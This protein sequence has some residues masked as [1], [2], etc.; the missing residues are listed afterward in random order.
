MRG[1]AVAFASELFIDSSFDDGQLD[2]LNSASM[3]GSTG[4]AAGAMV[5]L[6]ITFEAPLSGM[7]HESG[8]RSFAS[9]FVGMQWNRDLDYFCWPGHR[10]AYPPPK[11]SCEL[12]A[13]IRICAKL[14]HSGTAPIPLRYDHDGAG[15]AR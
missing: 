10:D 11:R 4:L 12:A 9:D 6:F 3:R 14:N 8:G 13:S 2:V 1:E 7:K 5:M 15:A